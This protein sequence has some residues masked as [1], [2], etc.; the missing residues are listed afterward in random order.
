MTAYQLIDGYYTGRTVEVDNGIIAQGY[1]TIEPLPCADD[2]AVR[3]SGETQTIVKKIDIPASIELANNY[4]IDSL[5][6]QKIYSFENA[7]IQ[8]EKSGCPFVFGA[9]GDTIQTRHERDLININGVATSAML[10][11]AAGITT[12]VIEFRAQ[13]DTSYM[14]TPDEAIGLAVA[15]AD[16]AAKL[17][18]SQWRLKDLVAAAQ[19]VEEINAINWPEN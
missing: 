3:L 17:Y 14:M 1:T 18:L 12:A 15:V 7:R 5:K 8:L 9:V 19:T 2:E 11:K 10:M 13:S 4:N 16:R 6:A